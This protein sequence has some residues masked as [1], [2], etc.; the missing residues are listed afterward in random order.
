M[1]KIYLLVVLVLVLLNGEVGFGQAS[2]YHPFPDSGAVWRMRSETLCTS[3]FPACITEYQYVC[4][5]D[6]IFNGYSY[7]KVYYEALETQCSLVAPNIYVCGAPYFRSY[8]IY[9]I[10]N[11][12]ANKK[13]FSSN[14]IVEKVLYDYSLNI[15]DTMKGLC[16]Q[17]S[18]SAI[19]SI[20]VGTDYRKRFI[21][22][23]NNYVIEGLGSI[24]NLSQNGYFADPFTGYC[25][26]PCICNWDLNFL[27]FS[28]NGLTLFPDTSMCSIIN[29]I[30][31]NKNIL[32]ITLSPNPTHSQFSITSPTIINEIKITDV[33]G[34][35]IYRAKPQEKNVVVE[36]EKEGIYFVSV[37]MGE[38]RVTKKIVVQQ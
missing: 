22:D 5:G 38:Q 19:D 7:I 23:N 26:N 21:L 6:T 27:C 16:D 10:R 30:Y 35:L 11:D 36:L 4:K 20:L 34:L 13:V 12:S 1:K 14:G 25:G 24:W 31:E 32:S 9:T 15:G 37:V 8:L 3:G 18:I 2:V 17:Q 28:Q 29:S 33:L